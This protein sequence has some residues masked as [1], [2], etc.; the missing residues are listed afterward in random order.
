VSPLQLELELHVADPKLNPVTVS[1]S[2]WNGARQILAD[3]RGLYL[4]ISERCK[5]WVFLFHD[6]SVGVRR[7]PLGT[8]QTFDLHQ[9]RT[10]AES[11]RARLACG[12]LAREARAQRER[13]RAAALA[14]VGTRPS[15]V[16]TR[17]TAPDCDAARVPEG[18]VK[19]LLADGDGLYLCVGPASKTWISVDRRANVYRQTVLGAYPTMAPEQARQANAQAR[20]AR[21]GGAV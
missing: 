16:K 18:R 17:L 6:P 8:L 19:R 12:A 11:Q 20:A 9:A 14:C 5:T 1:R 3:G 15:Q 13:R 2:G 21:T 4:E 7:L 10:W